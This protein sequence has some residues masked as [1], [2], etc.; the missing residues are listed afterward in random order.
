MAKRTASTA[1]T[2]PK[3][4]K[5]DQ[6]ASLSSFFSPP[7]PI[8]AGSTSRSFAD[9]DAAFARDLAKREGIDLGA[10]RKDGKAREMTRKKGKVVATKQEDSDSDDVIIMESV[11]TSKVPEAS[12][13]KLPAPTSSVKLEVSP[14]P[15]PTIAALGFFLK[16]RSAASSSTTSSSSTV[17]TASSILSKS[18]DTPL[19]SFNPKLD[20]N[21]SNWP[22]GR[23]PYAFLTE[24]FV[25]ISGTKSRLTIVRVLTNL[26]RAVIELDPDSLLREWIREN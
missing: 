9:A 17:N 13:S 19:Y 1:G 4:V 23:V 24:A 15:K 20:V 8:V 6:Q 14:P 10:L 26:L 18:L 2:T 7:K 21:T 16:S 3:R 22:K 5:L 12:T 11:P 25:L